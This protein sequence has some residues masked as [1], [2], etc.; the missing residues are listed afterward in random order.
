MFL[1][2]YTR[3]N[4]CAIALQV[5]LV[6]P[7]QASLSREY[8]MP[9]RG[10]RKIGGSVNVSFN[11][12]KAANWSSL[13]G[14]RGFDA[15]FYSSR[16]RGLSTTAKPVTNRRYTLHMARN[17]RSCLRVFGGSTCKSAVTL[18]LCTFSVPGLIK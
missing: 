8:W 3:G 11:L 16:V 14:G 17:E 2:A 6:C 10:K 12:L 4:M 7:S 1:L 5:H 9:G 18:G 13:R 15:P